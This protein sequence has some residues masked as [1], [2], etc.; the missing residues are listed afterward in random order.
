M[1]NYEPLFVSVVFLMTVFLTLLLVYRL[2]LNSCL[3]KKQANGVLLGL[4]AWIIF[5]M[6]MSFS[7]FYAISPEVN[8]PKFPLLVAPPLLFILFL[9]LRESGRRFMDSLSLKKLTGISVVRIPVEFVLYFLALYHAIPEL[10]TFEGANFD[11]LA[12]ISSL[13]IG[14]IAFRGNKIRVKMLLIWNI[15]SLGLLF[16]I[17]ALAVLSSP[18]SFQQLAFTTPNLAI[19]Y[20]PYALLPA[21]IVPVVLLSHLVSIRKLLRLIVF[22]IKKAD[23]QSA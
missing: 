1:L 12:G 16:T 10:M 6:A 23:R 17:I 21:F 4:S 8:P 14:G 11:I 18:F 9:F 5:Q 13:I 19:L 3:T 20:F 15:I 22:K 7:L 2:V